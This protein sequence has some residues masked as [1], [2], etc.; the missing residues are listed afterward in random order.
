MVRLVAVE[1]EEKLFQSVRRPTTFSATAASA[2]VPRM[3]AALVVVLTFGGF[4]WGSHEW[5][6]FLIRVSFLRRFYRKHE[7]WV[8]CS[9][10]SSC[11]SQLA[12]LSFAARPSICG[13]RLT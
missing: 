9:G 11:F 1:M 12:L 3:I 5:V 7:L 6:L 8:F 10:S 4:V 2:L 13:L